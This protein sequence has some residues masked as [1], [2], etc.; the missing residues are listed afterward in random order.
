[1]NTSKWSEFCSKIVTAKWAK[2]FIGVDAQA[3]QTLHSLFSVCFLLGQTEIGSRI[4]CTLKTILGRLLVP[5]CATSLSW[6]RKQGKQTFGSWAITSS[7]G[8]TRFMTSPTDRSALQAPNSS[9]M[10]HIVSTTRWSMCPLETQAQPSAQGRTKRSWAWTRWTS[11]YFSSWCAEAA[12][13]SY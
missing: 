6:K 11:P 13:S 2:D 3:F 12:P 10:A 7:A 1:M 5:P 4:S 8:T 9:Q